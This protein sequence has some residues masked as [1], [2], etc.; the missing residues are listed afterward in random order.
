MLLFTPKEV[1][2]AVQKQLNL[3]YSMLLFTLSLSNKSRIFLKLF[4]LQYV[5][6]YTKLFVQNLN[7]L[8]NYL[9]YSMLLFTPFNNIS[10]FFSLQFT[11]QYVA[12]YT[13]F[14]IIIIYI[15]FIFTLQY[16]AI[17]TEFSFQ[18]F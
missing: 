1:F 9:H 12:I 18:D 2:E 10:V 7:F 11:L 6:I 16:V 15:N 8:K 17:Y 5:A 13:I 14:K 3:H 4:T